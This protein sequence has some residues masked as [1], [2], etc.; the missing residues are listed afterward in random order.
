MTDAMEMNAE[1]MTLRPDTSRPIST[2]MGR[3]W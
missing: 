2:M 3:M 1:E